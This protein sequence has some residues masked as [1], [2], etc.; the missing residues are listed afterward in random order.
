MLDIPCI[1]EVSGHPAQSVVEEMDGRKMV[2]FVTFL[3]QCV[4]NFWRVGIN[5]ETVSSEEDWHHVSFY[6]QCQ[7]SIRPPIHLIQT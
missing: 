1:P 2:H 7:S 4:R 6:L 5:S 3:R